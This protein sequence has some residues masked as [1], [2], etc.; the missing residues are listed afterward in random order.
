MK[1]LTIT[2]STLRPQ[3]VEAKARIAAA[4]RREVWPLLDA[5][6]IAP[7]IDRVY[8]LEAAAEAHA[9]MESSAHVGQDHPRGGL[10]RRIRSDA[11]RGLP[12][13][14]GRGASEHLGEAASG[15][16]SGRRRAARPGHGSRTRRS[17]ARRGAARSGGRRG[18]R[19]GRCGRVGRGPGSSRRGRARRRGEHR[20]P[21]SRASRR[22]PR[23]GLAEVDRASGQVQAGYV[24]VADEEHPFLRRRAPAGAPRG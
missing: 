12:Q 23:A 20:L 5:R 6:R 7:V 2:G 3:S 16:R 18:R 21:S 8:P 13:V 4:L 22:P 11:R 19:R 9:R 17:R 14:R 10:S 24:G 15:C 1:R